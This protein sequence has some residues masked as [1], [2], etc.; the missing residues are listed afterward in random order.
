MNEHKSDSGNPNH[1]KKSDALDDAASSPSHSPHESNSKSDQKGDLSGGGASGGGQNANQQ[2]TGGPGKN[3]ASD[4]GASRAPGKGNGETSS[5]A[6][7]DK[8]SDHPTGQA[9]NE[10]GHGSDSKSANPNDPHAQPGGEQPPSRQNQP[11]NG[12]QSSP[13]DNNTSAQGGGGTAGI[14]RGGSRAG[15]VPDSADYHGVK[16][17]TEANLDFAR[18]QFDLA[19]D[20]LKKGNPDLL[21]ELHW[22][23]DDARRL[24]ERLEQMKQNAQLAGPQGEDARREMDDM[25]RSLGQRSGV[26][27]RRGDHSLDDSQRG[28]RESHDSGPPADYQEQFNAFQQGGAAGRTVGDFLTAEDAEG[29]E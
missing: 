12:T 6:G 8:K 16:T 5:E 26:L 18:K 24:A 2:G 14:P 25:L 29:Q 27:A 21:R 20:K 23:A 4:Q 9:G 13:Q 3:T 7:G 17:G 10:Q 19:L 11:E 1:D 28:L 22:T 15:D